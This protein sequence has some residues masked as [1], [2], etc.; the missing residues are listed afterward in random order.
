LKDFWYDCPLRF[1]GFDLL[2]LSEGIRCFVFDGRPWAWGINLIAVSIII[3]GLS[4]GLI[5]YSY[6][7]AP[8][9]AGK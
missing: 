7:I 2:I 3:M 1:N 9:F 4:F 6:L 5:R 8:D